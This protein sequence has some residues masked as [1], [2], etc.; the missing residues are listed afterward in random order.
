MASPQ[1]GLL[2]PNPVI[3]PPLT[4]TPKLHSLYECV[5]LV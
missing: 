5:S 3:R 4:L 1:M 2:K